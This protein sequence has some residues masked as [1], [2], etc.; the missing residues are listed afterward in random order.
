MKKILDIS[1]EEKV[2]QE[3]YVKETWCDKC[4]KSDLGIIELE[5]YIEDG[6]KFISGK[7]KVCGEKCITELIKTDYYD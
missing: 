7:C 6:R 1:L 2:L 5:L 4:S 3:S